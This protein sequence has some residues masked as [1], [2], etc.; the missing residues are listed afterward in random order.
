MERG[1]TTSD[2]TSPVT[3]QKASGEKSTAPVLRALLCDTLDSAPLSYAMQEARARPDGHGSQA[4]EEYNGCAY[5]R[6]YLPDHA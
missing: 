3:L 6:A 4:L 1:V 2:L 5:R